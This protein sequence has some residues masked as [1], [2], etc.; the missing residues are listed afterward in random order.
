MQASGNPFDLASN[1]LRRLDEIP[2]MRRDTL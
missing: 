1:L 2:E